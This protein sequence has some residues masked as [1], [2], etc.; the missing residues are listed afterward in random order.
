M[1]K[2]KIG[3]GSWQSGYGCGF[4]KLPIIWL[5]NE[6]LYA[7]DL[8]NWKRTYKPLEGV[9]AGYVRINAMLSNERELYYEASEKEHEIYKDGK[10]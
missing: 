2:I 9:F 4:K 3:I 1:E 10:I 8:K 5:I 7:K 6:K